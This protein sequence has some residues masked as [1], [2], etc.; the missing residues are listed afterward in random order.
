[1]LQTRVMPCLL[2]KGRALVRTVRFKN[3]KYVGDPVNT[4]RIFNEKEVDELIFLDITATP[5]RKEPPYA[6][7]EEIAAEC[8]MPFTYGG[9]VRSLQQMERLY[10]LGVEKIALN[11]AALADP[12][13]IQRA[14]E[15]FGSQS[16]VVAIDAKKTWRGYRVMTACGRQKTK[17][18]PLDWARE[19]EWRGAGEILLTSIDQD[20]AMQGYD[21]ALTE[22]VSAAVQ[23]PVIACGGAGSVEDFAR[24]VH[25]AGASAAATG[26]LVVYQGP[27]RAVLINFPARDE[28]EAVLA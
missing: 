2:L 18:T 17:R 4:I 3:P 28:L 10:S 7:L 24:V 13:L 9:G 14:A 11:T 5:E 27:H 22:S 16:V 6:L 15:R 1:M 25:D 23:V 12:E 26:S 20:G 19:A 21:L 8:F